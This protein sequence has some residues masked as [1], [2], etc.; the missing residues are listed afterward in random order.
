LDT[1][2]NNQKEFEIPE[3]P[4]PIYPSHNKH[5]TNTFLPKFL[6]FATTINTI[7]VFTKRI[8]NNSFSH[9]DTMLLSDHRQTP[10]PSCVTISNIR[11]FVPRTTSTGSARIWYVRIWEDTC[12]CG[13]FVAGIV[14]D[15][16]SFWA[17]SIGRGS[18]L[19]IWWRLVG[20]RGIWSRRRVWVCHWSVSGCVGRWRICWSVT[21]RRIGGYPISHCFTRRIRAVWAFV[22]S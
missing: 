21:W 3:K 22:C 1:C 9:P 14:V 20:R 11:S 2:K 10:L 18:W 6:D 15:K 12:R 7:R 4:L 17:I 13:G 19:N 8:A 16:A 5:S